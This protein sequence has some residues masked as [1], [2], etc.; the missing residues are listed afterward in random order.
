[1]NF[2]EY[3]DLYSAAKRQRGKSF[4]E[5][6]REFYDRVLAPSVTTTPYQRVAIE[7]ERNWYDN[8]RPY[9]NVWPG[10]AAKLLTL[11]ISKVRAS[12]CE[13]PVDPILIRFAEA[14]DFLFDDGRPVQTIL[15]AMGA[16]RFPKQMPFTSICIA[17][18]S[19]FETR[20]PFAL[21]ADETIGTNRESFVTKDMDAKR[22]EFSQ[23]TMSLCLSLCLLA[24]D[25][26][27]IE[28][29][30]LSADRTKF[31]E[32][33]EDKY[34]ERARRRGKVGW[35]VG[36]LVAVSPH[37]R[38]GH[39]A[40]RWTGK[41]GAVERIVWINSTVVKRKSVTD[42]PTGYLDIVDAKE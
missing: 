12:A 21:N 7:C 6:Y 27:I 33:L 30:V 4:T 18:S 1:M 11:D 42:V 22:A 14:T 34:V 41:G 31:E 10:I 35:N 13:L 2:Q 19:G 5:S 37:Y 3:C 39:F 8:K 40:L 26:S 38:R 20:I 9:Y 23:K 24:T 32:T 17:R 16:A 28:P 36:R 29:D 25:T 15:F